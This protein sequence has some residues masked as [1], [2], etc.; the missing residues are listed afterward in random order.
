MKI[1]VANI[2]KTTTG[3][4]L[5]KS[6]EKFGEVTSADL[7]LDQESGKSTGFAFVEMSSDEHAQNAMVKMN[8]K[9]LTDSDATPTEEIK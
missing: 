7:V 1:Y 4:Q 2:S 8:L 6:F 3:P 9:D 5:R